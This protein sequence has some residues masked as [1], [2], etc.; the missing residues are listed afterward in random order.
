MNIFDS[1]H[2][3]YL[4]GEFCV[5]AFKSFFSSSEVNFYFFSWL[6]GLFT[7]KLL[8][9]AFI[10]AAFMLLT[11]WQRSPKG[12][13]AIGV[14]ESLRISGWRSEGLGDT[15]CQQ[16]FTS[17]RPG[18]PNPQAC[19]LVGGGNGSFQLSTP[20]RN[21]TRLGKPQA[22]SSSDGSS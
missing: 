8:P 16:T 9:A 4:L 12:A 14:G 3:S 6:I 11:Q 22:P 10:P 19:I 1:T 20:E 13:K 5:T 7:P 18:H 2:D 15:P 17:K 21:R